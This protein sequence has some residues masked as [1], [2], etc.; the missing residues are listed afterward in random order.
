MPTEM[1]QYDTLVA[2]LKLQLARG[3]MSYAEAVG[4]RR[5]HIDPGR[6]PIACRGRTKDARPISTS[7]TVAL[8]QQNGRLIDIRLGTLSGKLLDERS[9]TLSHGGARDLLH[10]SGDAHGFPQLGD[11]AD[12]G[13]RLAVEF[14]GMDAQHLADPLQ[15]TGRYAV[16][17]RLVFLNLLK[18]DA[19]RPAERSL[20]H[21][22]AHA[23]GSEL[24][25]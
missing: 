12:R 20:V 1:E 21:A 18:A 23:S 6:S 11:T 14:P 15:G 2:N 24:G 25:A 3:G 4:R 10:S 5:H 7:T 17:A 9:E 8:I 22:G 19:K 16:S 13:G